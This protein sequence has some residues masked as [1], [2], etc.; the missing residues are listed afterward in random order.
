MLIKIKMN[1][2]AEMLVK[3]KTKYINNIKIDI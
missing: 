3:Y 1:K 2:N